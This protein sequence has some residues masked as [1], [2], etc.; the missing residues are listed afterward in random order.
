MKKYLIPLVAVL[1]ASCTSDLFTGATEDMQIPAEETAI[2]IDGQG[3]N[4]S[5]ATRAVDGQDAADLLGGRFHVYATNHDGVVFNN[6]QV[7]WKG[8]ATL[9]P[10][11]RVGW[12]Y[13]GYM[14]K[15]AIPALQQMKYWDMSQPRYDF[16]AFAGIADN[17]RISSVDANTFTINT[18][19]MGDVYVANR[20]SAAPAHVAGVPGVS[21]EFIPYKTNVKFNFRRATARLRMGIYETIPGYAVTDVRFYFDDNADAPMGTSAKT[22]AGLEGQFPVDGKF[23]ITYDAD[24]VAHTTFD[25]SGSIVTSRTLGVLNY[26]L[27]E[28]T[29][30]GFPYLNADGTP[31]LTGQKLFLGTTSATAS[32]ALSDE[33]LDG[34]A[35]PQSQWHPI[36]PHEDNAF[37]LRLRVDYT[38]VALDGTGDKMHVK[39]AEAYI[40]IE[41]CQW[42][43]NYSYTYIFKIS[44]N[45][46]YTGGADDPQG[47]YPITFDAEVS[48]AEEYA[49]HE[50]ELK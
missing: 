25:P 42:Q 10:T 11:N 48:S 6:Y 19:N 33:V 47:L 45:T 28:S 41:Y 12:E 22:V 16:V 30:P 32:F 34:V 13:Q 14:S 50:E 31:D 9:S 35:V 40:P 26:M 20:I 4:A 46:G 37:K 17:E 8:T 27:A 43:P 18:A 21:P 36:L 49:T 15:A 44:T 3:S 38:L 1:L 29:V 39:G 2:I 5:S 7:C 24:N 23:T